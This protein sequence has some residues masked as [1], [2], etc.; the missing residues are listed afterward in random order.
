MGANADLEISEEEKFQI[1]QRV[2]EENFTKIKKCFDR[3]NDAQHIETVADLYRRYESQIGGKENLAQVLS[4]I[5]VIDKGK[6]H[7][8]DR[9]L[10][11]MLK[12]IL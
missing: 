11:I 5:F 10:L 12:K 1:S 8:M 6:E 2:G 4:E 3:Q 7:V 9:Y